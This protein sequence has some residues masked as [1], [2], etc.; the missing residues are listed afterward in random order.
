M[1]ASSLWRWTRIVLVDVA[2]VPGHQANRR[3]ADGAPASVVGW[4]RVREAVDS[5][6]PSALY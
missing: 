6:E 2:I 5:C 3:V 4:A 1:I